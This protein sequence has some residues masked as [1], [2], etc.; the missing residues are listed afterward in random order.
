MA[1]VIAIANHKGGVAKTATTHNLGAA[2]A[3]LGKRVLMVDLDAQGNLSQ[4]TGFEETDQS[5]ATALEGGELPVFNIRENLDIVPSD[6]ELDYAD[7]HLRNAGVTGY[8][9]L[10]QV[11]ESQ[12]DNYDFVLLDCPPSVKGMIVSNAL[13]ASDSVLVPVVPE[14]GAIKGLAGIF[15][16]MEDC[17]QL[18][19]KL[20]IEGIVF[21]R[22][23]GNTALHNFYTEQIKE[24]Y[25]E[26]KIFNTSIRE[27][28][29]VSEAG[30]MDMDIF[31]HSPKSNGAE[32]HL[33][34]AKEIL[35]NTSDN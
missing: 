17:V 2:L 14:K 22:V 34:L 21:T 25:G 19:D 13:I 28:I 27:S 12:K 33:A 9:K 23:K 20:T 3:S 24:E 32:D 8:R 16:L 6:L 4:N 11:L 35:K 1:K 5:L 18:N 31:Q 10:G 26:V 7:E 29:S 30:T 15:R